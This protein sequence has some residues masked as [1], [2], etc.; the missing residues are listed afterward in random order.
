MV[1]NKI[2]ISFLI[3]LFA[4]NAA[5]QTHRYMVHFN[6]KN[7]SPYSIEQPLEF[8]SQ[9]A[10]DRRIQQGIVVDESD[11]PVNPQ[12]LQAIRDLG[13]TVYFT[14][15][16]F[17][18]AL[19]QTDISKLDLIK[20]LPEVANVE[21]VAKDTK[22]TLGNTNVDTS[23]GDPV[24]GTNTSNRNTD[25]QNQ[26]IGI[27]DM[28]QAGYTGE[29]ML[30]AI[31]DGGFESVNL[32]TFF[33]HL[34]ENNKILKTYDLVH[35]ELDVYT[36]DSS[37][38]TRVLSCMAALF[39]DSYSGS[40][41]D[42]DFM[43]FIT[44]DV[45]SEYRIE[46][47]NLVIAAEMADS[48]GV[49]VI[50]A[51]VGYNFFDSAYMDYEYEQM[52]G[53]TAVST[54][55]MSMAGNKGIAVVVSAGNEGNSAEWP[56]M[57]AP[58]DAA[59]ILATGASNFTGE[60]I[61]FSSQGPSSD[62]RIKP[63]IMAVG[64]GTVVC[65]GGPNISVSNGTSFAA[66]Q[67]AG[68]VTG[69]WQANPEWTVKELFDKVRITASKGTD[70]DNFNGYGIADFVR[71]NDFIVLGIEDEL[72]LDLKIFPNPI[73]DNQLIISSESGLLRGTEIQLYNSLGQSIKMV[74][75]KANAT[76]VTLILDTF[77]SGIYVLKV[78]SENRSWSY[79]VL[80]F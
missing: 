13:V 20:A 16:W 68:L 4:L 23:M 28:H 45:K 34:V 22:L 75:N 77:Q 56:Y 58:A 41:P 7:N 44:E 3:S 38:G 19:I 6:D 52:D 57:V 24:I 30:V 15:K 54:R 39:E 46:E 42:A 59:N 9:R 73:K 27:D 47:Y 67:I 50:N 80:K 60:R 31:M 61:G 37:H 63:D 35:N 65:N 79:R 8:L 70:P 69:L 74:K 43:L 66:P 36:D 12:Y 21:F 40:V 10:L 2:I 1:Q 32:S 49:D 11:L 55:G 71:A 33:S 17:N 72:S 18:A 53:A 26:L 51:S 29:G 62:D 78:S 14:S 25:L 5:A 48:A 76:R 64:L